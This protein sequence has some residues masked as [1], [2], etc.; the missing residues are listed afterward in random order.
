MITRRAAFE[1]PVFL[2]VVVYL[3][4]LFPDNYNI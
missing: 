3:A 2:Y 1:P 4:N